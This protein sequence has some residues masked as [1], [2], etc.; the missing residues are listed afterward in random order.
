MLTMKIEKRIQ[1]Y[2]D[3]L[4][5]KKYETIHNLSWQFVKEDRT[6]REP[7]EDLQWSDITLPHP[8]GEE[9]TSFWF[10]TEVELPSSIQGRETFLYARPQSD[11]LVFLNGKAA[12]ALNLHHERIR[13]AG[14]TES[15]DKIKIHIE[16]YGGH[17][18]PGCHPSEGQTV[19][20]TIQ[21]T[22]PDYPNHF[23]NGELQVKRE[24]IY[25]LYYDARTL[26]ETASILEKNSLRRAELLKALFETLIKIPQMGKIDQI[27]KLCTIASEKLKPLLSE[28]NSRTCPDVYL[29]GHAHIDH[30]WLWPIAETEKKIARTF[31]NMCRYAKEFP[32]FVFLQSHPAQLESVKENYPEVF[33]QIKETYK[34]GQWEPNGGMWVEADCNIPSGESLI[35]QFLYGRKTTREL[36]DY[37]G[38]TLWLPDVFGY[39]AA[40]P[41]ILKGCGIEYFVTSKINWNDTTRFPYD[42]FIWEGIDGTGVKTLFIPDCH[43]GYNGSVT[44]KNLTDSWNSIQHKEIQ[45]SY[46]KSVGEGDGGGGTHRSD[47]EM[48]E[49]LNDLEGT[50]R[51]KWQKI[52]DSLK[53]IFRNSPE[54]PNWKGELY[55]ELHRG[56]YT[57]QAKTKR[58]NRKLEFQLSRVEMLYAFLSLISRQSSEYPRVE[59]NDIW[60]KLLTN[61]FHDIIPGSSIRKVFEEAEQEYEEMESELSIL[62]Q[63]G[64]KDLASCVSPDKITVYNHLGFNRKGGVRLSQLPENISGSDT[65]LTLVSTEKESSVLQ[66]DTNL[67]GE[68]NWFGTASVPSLGWNTFSIEKTVME[69]ENRFSLVENRLVTPYFTVEFSAEGGIKTLKYHNHHFDFAAENRELNTFILAEDTPIFWDAWDIDAD[70]K[71]KEA[72]GTK[73]ISREVISL[74]PVLIRIRFKYSLGEESNITQDLICYADSPRIDFQTI[75]DWKERRSLLKTSF[76]LAIESDQAAG[77]VQFGHLIRPT[78]ENRPEDRARFEVCA[79]KWMSSS[80]G[81]QTAAV[82]ND[83]KYGW[84]VQGSTI[85]LTLLKAAEAPDEIADLGK[86]EFTYSLLPLTDGFSATVISEEAY[87]LNQPL[88]AGSS[89]PDAEKFSFARSSVRGII[90]ETVKRSEEDDAIILR[91]YEAEGAAQRSEISFGLA[92]NKVLLTTML[93][94]EIEEIE[95]LDNSI[96]LDFHRFEVKTLKIHFA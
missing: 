6:R 73:L 29:A 49:R 22:I 9:F 64:L 94:D 51:V 10:R 15:Y 95:S 3:F 66:R 14:K 88:F 70:Y 2:I 54:L 32:D 74:G 35:R 55:L 23:L 45:K 41:Q 84:D 27:E 39:A 25:N 46:I 59:L 87:D 16:S 90:I 80:D 44:P 19:V 17:Y 83:C 57:S 75:I 86:H 58:F 85:R 92:V 96:V 78:H 1:D 81:K 13:I 24:N 26:F 43:G 53:Q 18:Y 52:S 28:K 31:A 5:T 37:S 60:K 61:Q 50:P 69:P 30:A 7:P 4:D 68:E 36:L 91:L 56:T 40:L 93:E 62:E 67:N 34:N 12:G 48:A 77:D 8:Y 79:H 38:D 63:R 20:F 11:S 76:P 72:R 82:L 71:C 21:K 89:I 47:L 65:C 42:K 33:R